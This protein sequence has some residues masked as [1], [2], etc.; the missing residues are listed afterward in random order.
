MA[1]ASLPSVGPSGIFPGPFLPV[2]RPPGP[3]GVH[4]PY[5]DDGSDTINFSWVRQHHPLVVDVLVSH[6]C[7]SLWPDICAELSAKYSPA[8]E[9]GRFSERWLLSPAGQTALLLVVEAMVGA[10]LGSE[11]RAV[12]SRLQAMV[13]VSAPPAVSV[14]VGHPGSHQAVSQGA[15]PHGVAVPVLTLPPT[16]LGSDAGSVLGSEVSVLLHGAPLRCLLSL[17]GSR[18]IH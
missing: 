10:F 11:L 18:L 4:S 13:Q 1:S 15:A 17:L 12:I 3:P 8:L 7:P 16:T 5:F 6:D 14:P 9:A 2:V